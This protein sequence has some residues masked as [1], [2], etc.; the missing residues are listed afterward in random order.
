MFNSFFFFFILG[1]SSRNLGSSSSGATSVKPSQSNVFTPNKPAQTVHLM[2]Q[3][4][5]T[6]RQQNVVLF[7]K[8]STPKNLPVAQTGKVYL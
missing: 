1:T 7:Q 3:P 5:T 2:A 4:Q 6:R 8:G